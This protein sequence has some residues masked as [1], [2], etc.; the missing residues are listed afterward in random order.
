MNQKI[1]VFVLCVA[2][3]ATAQTWEPIPMV[4]QKQLDAG[5]IGGEGFQWPQSLEVDQ[6]DGSFILYGTDVGGIWRSTD[7]GKLFEP[8]NVG[9]HA[10][11]NCGF[12]IDPKNNSRALAVAG[13]SFNNRYHGLYLTTDKG[14]S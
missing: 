6:V 2:V 13:N 8:A 7:H 4:S 9:Y 3:S 12:A 5:Y 10:R 1:L 11:G 14:A